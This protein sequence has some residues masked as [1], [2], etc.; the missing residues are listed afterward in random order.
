MTHHDIPKGCLTVEM[1]AAA[2][3]AVAQFRGVPF[4]RL[5]QTEF[6][7]REVVLARGGS[8]SGIVI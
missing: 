6:R 4:A 1:E 3:F 8:L 2:F 7:A 5:A